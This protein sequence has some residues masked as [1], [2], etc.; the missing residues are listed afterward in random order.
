MK[1][2]RIPEAPE[3]EE[4]AKRQHLKIRKKWNINP[5]EKI[6]PSKKK[7]EQKFS[8]KG[9]LKRQIERDLDI[10]EEE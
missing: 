8:N 5:V 10:Y 6:I 9:N 3:V 4:E 7:H 2:I 1:K